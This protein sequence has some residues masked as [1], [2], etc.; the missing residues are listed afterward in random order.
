[1]RK[2]VARYRATSLHLK[3][4][5]PWKVSGMEQFIR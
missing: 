4:L 2:E 5:L 1:M 3:P